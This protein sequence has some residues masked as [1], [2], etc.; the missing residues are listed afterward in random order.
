MPTCPRCH[1][2]VRA[3]DV[4]CAHCGT[5]LKAFG[6]AGIEVYRAEGEQPLCLSCAY[7]ADDSCSYPQHPLAREC[8]MYR[9]V[10]QPIA[11]VRRFGARPSGTGIQKAWI[12]ATIVALLVLVLLLVRR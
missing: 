2:V 9:D 5:T 1:Q 10:D 7:H 11:P 8:T 4:T 3:T 12:V 6:H